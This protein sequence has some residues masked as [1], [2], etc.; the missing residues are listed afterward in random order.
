MAKSFKDGKGP[1]ALVKGCAGLPRTLDD[2]RVP[3]CRQLYRMLEDDEAR[4]TDG[5]K[6]PTGGACQ[7]GAKS[8]LVALEI[9]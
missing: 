4:A 1:R 3:S 5:C 2:R 7:H 8:W 9:L 6:V